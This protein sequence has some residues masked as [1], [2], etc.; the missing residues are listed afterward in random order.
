[1]SAMPT[2]DTDLESLTESEYPGDEELR[3]IREWDWNDISGL[4]AY[5]RERWRW[6]D[7]GYWRREG[8]DL[9][10]STGGWSGNEDLIFALKDNPLVWSLIW[11]Q[12]TR[13][14]HYILDLSVLNRLVLPELAP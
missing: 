1:M 5:M 7:D 8:S 6:A 14:G 11:K 2:A 10:L 12:S 4:L 9:Y 13:G 3:S